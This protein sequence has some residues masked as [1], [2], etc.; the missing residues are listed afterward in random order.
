[1]YVAIYPLTNGGFMFSLRNEKSWVKIA[2][3]LIVLF[4]LSVNIFCLSSYSSEYFLMGN[5]E[6]ADNDDVR[7]IRTAQML[8]EKGM[9]IDNDV[10]TPAVNMMPGHPFM[11]AFFFK[12]FGL[13]KG[14]MAFR[15]FQVILQSLSLFLIFLI[16][17]EVFKTSLVGLIA[18]LIDAVYVPEISIVGLVLMEVSFK[19]FLLLLIYIT[20]HALRSKSTG[21][22]IT[23]GVIWA[24]TCLIRPTVSMFPAIVLVLWIMDK[25]T[26]KDM[27]RYGLIASAVF[28]IIMSPWWIRNYMTFGRFIPLSL[29]SGNPFLQGTYINYD[30]TKNFIYYKADRDSVK[31]DQLEM[32]LGI[33]RLKT[34]FPKSPLEYIRWYTIGKTWHYWNLPYYWKKIF[35]ISFA[36]AHNMHNYIFYGFFIGLAICIIRRQKEGTIL[37]LTL[38]YF[39]VIH[40]P[41]YTFSRYAYP[42]MP[43]VIIY[44]AYGVYSILSIKSIIKGFASNPLVRKYFDAF[45]LRHG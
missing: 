7:Y 29:G 18:C 26:F 40:L 21:L 9:L 44:S 10:D 20:I 22:Y 17:R 12:F 41:Y 24:L 36:S 13:A 27:L 38:A 30:Q 25:Y 33:Q 43:L 11:L 42:V 14:I 8:L 15:Y 45:S 32:K 3:A 31:T 23:G 6:K 2:F 4:S 16:C 19:F 1:M 5:I 34:H 39:T 37:F 28:S 35:D